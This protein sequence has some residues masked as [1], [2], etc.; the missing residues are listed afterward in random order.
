[1]SLEK[2]SMAS[3]LVVAVIGLAWSAYSFGQASQGQAFDQA[4]YQEFKAAELPDKCQTPPGY[5]DQ[6]WQEHM[7]HHPEQ[8]QECF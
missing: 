3:L 2:I 5:T 6:A 7:S 1:M 4:R 8:Y